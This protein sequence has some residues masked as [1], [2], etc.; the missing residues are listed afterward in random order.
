MTKPNWVKKLKPHRSADE[1]GQQLS[2]H[3]SELVVGH[4][5]TQWVEHLGGIFK[6]HHVL[7]SI[8]FSVLL[9]LVVLALVIALTL[10]LLTFSLQKSHLK[11]DLIISIEILPHLLALP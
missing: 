10:L 5:M 9:V 11:A 7:L 2:E 3:P 8:I 4:G 1:N 6:Q